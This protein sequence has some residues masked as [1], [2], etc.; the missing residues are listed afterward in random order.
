MKTYEIHGTLTVS[1]WTSVEADSKEEAIEIA[2]S[3]GVAQHSIDGS[4]PDDECWNF[5][6][7]GE[8]DIFI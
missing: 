2:K 3:L 5:D 7:D 8:P 6:N 4:F 1:C